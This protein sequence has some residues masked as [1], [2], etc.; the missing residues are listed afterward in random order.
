MSEETKKEERVPQ[1]CPFMNQ[2]CRLKKCELYMLS[3]EKCV[4]YMLPLLMSEKQ[5]KDKCCEIPTTPSVDSK[6]V[7]KNTTKSS[8]K[9]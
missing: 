5:G 7:K 6:Q 9:T 4:F 8:G 3:T 1:E 2:L